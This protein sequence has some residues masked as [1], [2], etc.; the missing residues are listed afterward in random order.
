MERFIILPIDKNQE[1]YYA[2]GM[3]TKT[4]TNGGNKIM[5]ITF[6]VVSGNERYQVRDTVTNG[7]SFH[8]GKV[9]AYKQACIILNVLRHKCEMTDNQSPD[10]RTVW[11]AAI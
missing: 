7:V 6:T 3:E 11:E 1:Y 4:T 8:D 9:S 5:P 10:T 2:Y